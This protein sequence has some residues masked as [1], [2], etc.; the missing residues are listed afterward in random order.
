MSALMVL[1]IPLA[2]VLIW[3]VPACRRAACALAPWAA[4]PALM[5][6]LAGEQPPLHLDAVLLGTV[7]ALD[8][9][10]RVFLGF[11]ALLWLACGIHARGHL[12]T[13]EKRERFFLLW[14]ATMT[15]NFGLI[16]AQD[17]AS[18]YLFFALMTFAAYGLVVHDGSDPARR[19]GRVY[20][21][22]AVLGEGL[23]ISGLLMAASHTTSALQ[24]MLA[25]LP[26]AIASTERPGPILACLI[27]GFG[28]KAGLPLL[29]MWLP[30]AH[31]VAPIP[32]SAVLSGAMIKAGVMGWMTTLP[33]GLAVLEGW[34]TALMAAGLL[35]AFGGALVGVQQRTPK[36]VL[37]Y[38][39]ISQMGFITLALGSA[40][41]SPDLWPVLAPVIA[42]FALHHGLA[43][44]AL[45]LAV[46]QD[47]R[48]GAAQWL[49]IALPGL[50]L[51]G[52]GA[53][54]MAAK[55]ALKGA[56]Y[57][58]GD[59]SWWAALPLLLSCA[60]IGTTLLIARYL[61]LLHGKAHTRRANAS[62]WAG[63]GLL[64]VASSFAVLLPAGLLWSEAWPGRW[65][66]DGADIFNLVWPVAA[67][68]AMSLLAWRWMKPLPIPAGDVL[69]LLEGG[70]Q[71][72]RSAGV[73]VAALSAMLGTANEGLRQTLLRS[74][75]GRGVS[76]R[77]D[78]AFRRDAA[79]WLVALVVVL[80]LLLQ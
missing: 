59:N 52:L 68:A 70:W 61:W 37:A 65:P 3:C 8:A 15:G 26:A 21:A 73:G 67:G 18:F 45:F 29:H 24:P 1:L 33:L 57:G 43:K 10:G 47:H 19:A 6:A 40:L 51:A 42:L 28:I 49:L 60:A 53:S 12:A 64:V 48:F 27:T 25:D 63:W 62:E 4:L 77:L 46:G 13:D 55:L 9:T 41:H 31:P 22:M 36:T 69:A 56:L 76:T 71:H 58:A 72:I 23:I 32:A 11:T 44:G 20:L 5:L 66:K 17:V 34:G 30:L 79:L 38:S 16:L 14:L 50:S 39:S 2:L 54:G 35:A 80:I 75:R 78:N 74:V 7:L